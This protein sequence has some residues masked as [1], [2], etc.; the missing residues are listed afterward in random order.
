[1]KEVR[2]NYIID[3]GII[4]IHH[5]LDALYQKYVCHIPKEIEEKVLDLVIETADLLNYSRKE[6]ENVDIQK[7][8]HVKSVVNKETRT[9]NT[10]K[11]NH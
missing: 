4:V 2:K 6:I 7:E 3:E 1:M 5:V 10:K 11:N 9:K 8:D